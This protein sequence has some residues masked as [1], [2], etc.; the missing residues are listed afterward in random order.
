MSHNNLHGIPTNL[1]TSS[2]YTARS[3]ASKQEASQSLGRSVCSKI[4]EEPYKLE[5]RRHETKHQVD[6]TRQNPLSTASPYPTAFDQLIPVTGNNPLFDTSL[7]NNNTQQKYKSNYVCTGEPD[8]D[9]LPHY[10]LLPIGKTGDGKSS[11]LNSMFG[12]EEFKAAATAKSVTDTVVERTGCWTVNKLNTIVTVADTP[13]FADSAGR[14]FTAAI[15]NYILDVS[16]RIGIDAFLLVFQ[17]KSTESVV[18]N[19]LK[20][21]DKLMEDIEPN[22]WW[23]HV[24]LVFTRFDYI[25]EP[26]TM[27]KRKTYISTTLSEQIREAFKLEKAPKTVFVSSKNYQCPLLFGKECD[28]EPVRNHQNTRMRL[29]KEAIAKCS[30]H[31]RWRG[32]RKRKPQPPLPN[33]NGQGLSG[34]PPLPIHSV[35]NF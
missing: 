15:Q 18:M 4:E 31:G 6:I 28:C 35:N 33:R 11:L 10:V 5:L 17:F 25:K 32:K 22:N 2:Y 20:A 1:S 27:V 7:S 8:Q 23:D 16:D 19:I 29:L 24:V 12:Y 26:Q 13:G 21:F 3:Y 9:T 34:P 14:D 30:E